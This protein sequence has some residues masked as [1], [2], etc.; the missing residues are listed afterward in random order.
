MTAH[1]TARAWEDPCAETWCRGALQR[2]LYLKKQGGSYT[3][4]VEGENGRFALGHGATVQEAIDLAAARTIDRTPPRRSLWRPPH[5]CSTVVQGEVPPGATMAIVIRPALSQLAAYLSL[6]ADRQAPLILKD[7]EA[8]LPAVV[9]ILPT[10]A[11]FVGRCGVA[12]A[13]ASIGPERPVVVTLHNPT[14]GTIGFGGM[15]YG[16]V[17]WA[18]PI[19]AAPLSFSVSNSSEQALPFH[20]VISGSS[21]GPL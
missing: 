15:L 21:A 5:A 20:A 8:G 3:A 6:E 14:E 2:V 10:E 12:L 9:P 16:V 13:R 19:R 18:N 4:L 1:A 11:V 7:V 17:E